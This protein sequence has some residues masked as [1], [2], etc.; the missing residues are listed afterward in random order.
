MIDRIK[1]GCPKCGA[2]LEVKYESGIEGKFVTC[3]VCKKNSPFSSFKKIVNNN[4]NQGDHTIVNAGN[5]NYTLGELHVISSS[6]KFRLNPGR[7]IIGR[8][9]S[10]SS[11]TFQ[12]PCTSKR[13]S[14]EHLVIEVK[15]VPGKGYVH[16]VSLNKEHVN[17]TYIGNTLLEYGDKLVL[18]DRD[19]IHLPDMD[20]RF[21]IPD[22]DKTDTDY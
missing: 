9:S 14:R 3:P 13:M 20:I 17:P 16:H 4:N 5:E 8:K 7:N 21:E 10:S 15:K 2:I 1:I 12:L 18:N 19:I 22:S 6:I 11:A